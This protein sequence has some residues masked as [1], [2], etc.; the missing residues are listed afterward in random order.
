[1]ASKLVRNLLNSKRRGNNYERL[2]NN[3]DSKPQEKKKTEIDRSEND[4]I[5]I[6]E[7]FARFPNLSERIFTRLDDRSLALCREVNK[8]WKGFV[9]IQRIY[10]IRKI[11]FSSYANP[12]SKF[13]GEWKIILDKTPIKFLKQFSAYVWMKPETESCPL[14]V[15]AAVGDIELFNDIKEKTGLNENSKN[16]LGCTPF[17]V[18]AAN[19][20]LS[21]CEAIIEKLQDKNPRDNSGATPLHHAAFHGYLKV[22]QLIMDKVDDKYPKFNSGCTPLHTAAAAGHLNICQF[23]YE[24]IIGTGLQSSRALKKLDGMN[25]EDNAGRTPLHKAAKNGHI[26]VCKFFC[27]ILKEKNPKNS[28]GVTPLHVA[29]EHGQLDVCKFLCSNLQEK[30]PKDDIGNTPLNNACSN[31]HWKVVHFLIVENNLH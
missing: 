24:N 25:P 21:L 9:D 12:Q 29:A 13:H 1:M 11:S 10:W 28:K 4:Q 6:E 3:D 19:N 5:T 27:L 14:H 7:I 22:Y 18:A 26:E 30:N 2:T 31:E 8:T 23:F 20:R 16:N 15:A 17:H